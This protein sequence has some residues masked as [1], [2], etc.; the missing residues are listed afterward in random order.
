MKAIILSLALLTGVPLVSSAQAKANIEFKERKHDFGK[1]PAVRKDSVCF[2]FENTGTAPLVIQKVTTTC[3]CT[4]SEWSKEPIEPGSN[5]H[6]KVVFN[7]KGYNG[8]FSK[9]I[10]VKS[11]AETD[12]VL[13]KITGEVMN[14]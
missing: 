7:P 3:G 6:V 11:N 5:G 13:L 8:T 14:D 2:Y 12:V 10:F 1:I 9:S 4:A